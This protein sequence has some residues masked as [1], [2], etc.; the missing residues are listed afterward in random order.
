[1]SVPCLIPLIALTLAGA[2]PVP[3]PKPAA[4]APASPSKPLC[5]VNG[6]PVHREGA[7]LLLHELKREGRPVALTTLGSDMVD[8]ELLRQEAVRRGLDKLPEIKRRQAE[9]EDWALSAICRGQIM[10]TTPASTRAEVQQ[11]LGWAQAHAVTQFEVY[12][13]NAETR[14]EAQAK[15]DA[16]RAGLASRGF[17][18]RLENAFWVSREDEN[19]APGEWE[20]LDKLLKRP[21]PALSEPY[22]RDGGYAILQTTGGQRKVDPLLLNP[23][24][25]YVLDEAEGEA[26]SSS[27]DAPVFRDTFL[28]ALHERRL[29]ERLRAEAKLP[30]YPTSGAAWPPAQRAEQ[31]AAD[32]RLLAQEARRRGLD[33]APWVIPGVAMVRARVLAKACADQEKADHPVTETALREAFERSPEAPVDYQLGAR[34]YP[35]EAKAKAALARLRAGQPEPGEEVLTWKAPKVIPPPMLQLLR[36][37]ER[38]AY[39]DQPLKDPGGDTWLLIRWIQARPLEGFNAAFARNRDGLLETL[40]ERPANALVNRLRKAAKIE[41]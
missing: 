22:A 8:T 27:Q 16:W 15:R 4:A 25:A 17:F 32:E 40:R 34:G 2:P 14:A 5:R 36:G 38:G 37:L 29:L 10:E 41:D 1:M 13:G 23:L 35:T 6:V 20:V 11:A 18:L 7:M 26:K 3:K 30:P 9:R 28:P 33:K 19:L 12:R 21:A 31:K 24:D 39:P